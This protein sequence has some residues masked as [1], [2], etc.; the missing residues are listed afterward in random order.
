MYV[1]VLIIIFHLIILLFF[2]LVHGV[3]VI[4]VIVQELQRG[5][6]NITHAGP[7]FMW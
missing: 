2:I 3:S 5:V 6:K 4:G 1:D 7:C